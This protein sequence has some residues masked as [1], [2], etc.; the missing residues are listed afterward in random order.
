MGPLIPNYKLCIDY[1]GYMEVGRNG[2]RVG[3]RRVIYRMI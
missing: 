2:G 1:S 3:V